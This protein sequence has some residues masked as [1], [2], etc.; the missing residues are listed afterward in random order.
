MKM[1]LDIAENQNPKNNDILVF[2]KDDGKWK[3]SSKNL[4][5]FETNKKIANMEKEIKELR[6]EVLNQK[7][8][9]IEIAKI[10]KGEIE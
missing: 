4:F 1:V 7:N 6:D 10:V 5:L 3:V 9:I 8:Q 2:D